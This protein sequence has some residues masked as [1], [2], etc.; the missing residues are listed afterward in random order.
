MRQQRVNRTDIRRARRSRQ[1]R[2]EL[3]SAD[4][5][6]VRAGGGPNVD[7]DLLQRI[8]RIIEDTAAAGPATP[9]AP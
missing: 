2:R 8:N 3:R 4:A 6:I 9:H 1:R 5:P 7:E